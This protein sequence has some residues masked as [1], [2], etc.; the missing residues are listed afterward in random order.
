MTVNRC[1][2]EMLSDSIEEL[3]LNN[4]LGLDMS[5]RVQMDYTHNLKKSIAKEI[6]FPLNI[7]FDKSFEKGILQYYWKTNNICTIHK[8]GIE[9]DGS[10]YR[11][12]DL[13]CLLCKLL[14]FIRIYFER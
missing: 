7:V 4:L 14:D 8:K 13:T 6:C 9:Y 1:D 12:V 11:P 2:N 10:N 3:I 5:K